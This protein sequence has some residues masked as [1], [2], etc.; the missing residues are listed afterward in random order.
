MMRYRSSL[1]FTSLC[2]LAALAMLGC[3]G[4]GGARNA[5]GS[6]SAQTLSPTDPCASR[7]HE[8]CGG[9]LFYYVAHHRLPDRLE[10]LRQAEPDL[11]TTPFV[12]PVSN[13]PYIY[14]PAGR[15]LA[16]YDGRF[17]VFDAAP[18]HLGMRWAISIIEPMAGGPLVTKVIAVPEDKF[19]QTVQVQ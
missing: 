3:Q 12:C 9:F 4:A 15:I 16:G 11:A 19:A 17:I 6:P 1:M 10:D 18:T 8:M 14:E 7:L 5:V 13:L 2:L